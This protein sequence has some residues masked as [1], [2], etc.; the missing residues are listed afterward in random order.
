MKVI[1]KRKNDSIEAAIVSDSFFKQKDPQIALAKLK[2]WEGKY[3]NLIGEGR[4]II[5]DIKTS[6]DDLM[7]RWELGDLLHQFLATNAEFEFDNYE[8]SLARDLELPPTEKSQTEFAAADI[9]AL[10]GL[11]KIFPNKEA[12]DPRIT[13]NLVYFTYE[14]MAPAGVRGKDSSNTRSE[15]VNELLEVA[16]HQAKLGIKGNGAAKGVAR[17]LIQILTKYNLL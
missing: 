4:R 3:R 10:L 14:I 5:N 17:R 12:L 7:L 16:N 9:R 6:K 15:I 13:W 2:T 1:V 11:K 8:Q